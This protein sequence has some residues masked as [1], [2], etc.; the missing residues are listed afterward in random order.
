MGLDKYKIEHLVNEMQGYLILDMYDQ[1]IERADILI[2]N[3]AQV[4]Q[5]LLHK[6]E[7]LKAKNQFLEAVPVY[8]KLLWSRSDT[9]AEKIAL[10]GLGWCYKRMNRLDKAISCLE[11]LAKKQPEEAIAYFNL[12][13]YYSLDRRREASLVHLKKAVD[14]DK[15]YKELARQDQDYDFIRDDPEFKKIIGEN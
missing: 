3:N 11:E 9:E 8:E 5:A 13:C 12:S 4:T 2:R 15:H 10:L 14:M 7:A 1:V 6:S